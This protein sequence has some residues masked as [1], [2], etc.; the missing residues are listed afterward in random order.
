MTK[1]CTR[2]NFFLKSI[3]IILMLMIF[4]GF[5]R[6][7]SAFPRTLKTIVVPDRIQS[8]MQPEI[9]YSFKTS[10]HR[11]KVEKN[12]DMKFTVFN[13]YLT[14]EP[15]G[16]QKE[17]LKYLEAGRDL[18]VQKKKILKDGE[19]LFDVIMADIKA[20]PNSPLAKARSAIA[21]IMKGYC[22]LVIESTGITVL[23]PIFYNPE[24]KE[25]EV[26]YATSDD[27]NDTLYGLFFLD[28]AFAQGKPVFG[29]CHGAQLG[30]LY[31][32]GGL[33]RLFP[34]VKEWKIKPLYAR[35]NP[36]GA[37]IE[38]W[39][40]DK[41]LNARDQN[42][43]TE[44]ALIKYP[45]PKMFGKGGVSGQAYVNKDLNHTLGMTEPVPAIDDF[46]VI[47]YHPL[48]LKKGEVDKY[49]IKGNVPGYP[50]VK[51]A[52]REEFNKALRRGVIVDL[53]KFKTLLG[54]QYHPQYTYDSLQTSA[55]FD[56]LV[57]Q[58]ASVH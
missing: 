20:N 52:N 40:I 24:V 11:S 8:H 48:S 30:Y 51:D 21:E 42:D 19:R 1:V 4:A 35:K 37:P 5:L 34:P 32:G 39:A 28:A 38:I 22:L 55:V 25:L 36:Y 12:L 54:F 2:S 16:K 47:S 49:E 45:L 43:R 56:Y 26:G 13:P 41:M 9:F 3:F 17:V 15:S 46:E 10:A 58:A 7:T 31:A 27:V 53:Y 29:T 14:N 6:P 33:I 18:V 57:T 50:Q 23:H 44:Y